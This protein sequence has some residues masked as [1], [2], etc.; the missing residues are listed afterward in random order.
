MPR[1]AASSAH[2][3]PPGAV[4][5]TLAILK[6]ELQG[7]EQRA[8]ELRGLVAALEVYAANGLAKPTPHSPTRERFRSCSRDQ[9]AVP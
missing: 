1:R 6:A 8:T 3:P 5:D 4:A 2:S 7:Y 9:D